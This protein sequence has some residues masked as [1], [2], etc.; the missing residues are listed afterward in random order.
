[1]IA[2][3]LGGNPSKPKGSDY[4]TVPNNWLLVSIAQAFGVDHVSYGIQAEAQYANGTLPR[5]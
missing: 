3:D 5:L 2:D 4:Q 1:M